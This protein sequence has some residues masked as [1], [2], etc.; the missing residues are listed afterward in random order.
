M[1][2]EESGIKRPN[3]LLMDGLNTLLVADFGTGDL[4]RTDL[5]SGKVKN[6]NQGFGGADGLVRD[7]HG[8][9]Y[10]SDWQNGKVW[11]LAGPRATPQLIADQL[12]AA[13]D[14]AL[15]ADGKHLLIPDMKA[16]EMLYLP[17]R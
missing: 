1:L 6:L 15:S 8:F 9:L 17:I 11:Q 16:G 14:I 12:Q 2:N 13:A 10:V 7:T 3:G 4:Y 5:A